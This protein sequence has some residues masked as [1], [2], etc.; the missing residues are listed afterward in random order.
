[1]EHPFASPAELTFL[2][3][4]GKPPISEWDYSVMWA[5]LWMVVDHVETLRPEITAEFPADYKAVIHYYGDPLFDEMEVNPDLSV[6][7]AA[8]LVIQEWTNQNVRG[9]LPPDNNIIWKWVDGP[10]D[11]DGGWVKTQG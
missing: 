2:S 4:P 9:I 7:Q 10:E 3:N 11:Q 5:F 1:M 6:E 8:I